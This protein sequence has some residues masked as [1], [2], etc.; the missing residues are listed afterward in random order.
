[1]AVVTNGLSLCKIHHGAYDRNIIGISP[2]YRV[3]VR[4]EVLATVDGPT[5]Q[6]A[7]KEMN[8]EELRQIPLSRSS[9]PDKDL[10]AERFEQFK[11]AS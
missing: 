9:R 1:R 7:I 8:G 3:H 10:L 2:D 11:A 4:D 5:L 6:H